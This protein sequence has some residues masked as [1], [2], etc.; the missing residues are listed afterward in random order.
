MRVPTSVRLR[1]ETMKTTH[2]L[3]EFFGS[4]CNFRKHQSETFSPFLA[5]QR[6]SLV[7]GKHYVF[8]F[9]QNVDYLKRN[10]LDSYS[11]YPNY[12]YLNLF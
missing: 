6:H 12:R 11:L 8:F 9:F 4:T 3:A 10:I 7:R 5:L 1:I 2:L